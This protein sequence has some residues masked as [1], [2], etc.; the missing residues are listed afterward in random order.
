MGTLWLKWLFKR[1]VAS[2]HSQH[3]SHNIAHKDVVD[4]RYVTEFMMY[5]KY[6]HV[7]TAQLKESQQHD[8]SS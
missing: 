8:D 1:C 4:T 5:T 7:N 6:T 3:G 2:D